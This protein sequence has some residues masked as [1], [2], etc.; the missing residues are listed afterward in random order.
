MSNI[1]L[2]IVDDEPNI[3]RALQRMLKDAGLELL[4][5]NSPLEALQIVRE[6]NVD[7]IMSD[8][9]MP[10]MKGVELLAKVRDEKPKVVRIMMTAVADRDTALRAINECHVEH[11][12]EKPWDDGELRQL[13][14]DVALDVLAR[15][16][17][18]AGPDPAAAM[19]TFRPR[20]PL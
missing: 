17:V 5:A 13:L 10:G 2:L 12:L 18:M 8:N 6:Q 3:T 4:T 16:T 20:I 14:R 19:K 1:K 7:V 9:L 15:R 11:L